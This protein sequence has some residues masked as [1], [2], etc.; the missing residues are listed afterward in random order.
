MSGIQFEA[1]ANLI[2]LIGSKLVLTYRAD[3]MITARYVYVLL[4]RVRFSKIV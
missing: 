4:A 3:E 1:V 2:L